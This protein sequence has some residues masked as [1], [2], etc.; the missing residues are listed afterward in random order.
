MKATTHTGLHTLVFILCLIRLSASWCQ[1]Y[2]GVFVSFIPNTW[3]LWHLS[4]YLT[5]RVTNHSSPS[6]ESAH[7]TLFF[8]FFFHLFLFVG[9]WL[10]YNIVVGFAIHWHESAMDL[11]VFPI[12][13]PPPTSLPIP[14]LWVIPVHQPWALVSCIQPGLVICFTLDSIR[15]AMLFSQNF[16]PSPSP[17]ESQSLFCTSVP[18]FLFCILGYHYHLFKF[19]LEAQCLGPPKWLSSLEEK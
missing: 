1:E 5:N 2:L 4:D 10:L 7:L 15:V 16:P 14:S 12:L 9:G 19:T 8:F 13:N 6:R 17:T 11:H 3:H 18:L